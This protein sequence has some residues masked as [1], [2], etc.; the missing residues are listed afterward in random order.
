[1]PSTEA[2]F[3]K[4]GLSDEFLCGWALK[5]GLGVCQVEKRGKDIPG[6]CKGTTG[7][8]KKSLTDSGS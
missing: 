8:D 3:I 2:R 6:A 7:W 1:M 4:K 5:D